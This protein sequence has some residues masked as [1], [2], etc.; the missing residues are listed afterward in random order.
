MRVCTMESMT[1]TMSLKGVE[2]EESVH[3][4]DKNE[5]QREIDEIMYYVQKIKEVYQRMSENEQKEY[6]VCIMNLIQ[7]LVELG[8]PDV[9]R[10]NQVKGDRDYYLEQ[11]KRVYSILLNKMRTV[12]PNR[13]EKR[14]IM[15][16]VK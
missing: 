3:V 1:K 6:E 7:G 14:V 11:T 16:K 10:Y 9:E 12:R 2:L 15:K 5:P 8:I 4:V 13:S